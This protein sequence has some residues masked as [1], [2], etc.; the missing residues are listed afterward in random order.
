MLSFVQECNFTD[1]VSSTLAATNQPL[2]LN[3]WCIYTLTL[4][5]PKYVSSNPDGLPLTE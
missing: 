4:T 3:L 1:V 5:L 2:L